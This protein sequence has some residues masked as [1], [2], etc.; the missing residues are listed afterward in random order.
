MARKNT[1][2][3]QLNNLNDFN[4]RFRQ[5]RSIAKNVFGIK[6]IE[7]T[8]I[9]ER[10][11]N[12]KLLYKGALAFYAEP[13]VGLLAL[14][15]NSMGSID[16]FGEPINIQCYGANGQK[17]RILRPGEYVIMYDNT[18]RESILPD[19][20]L[21]AQRMSATAR[22]AD[23]N[24]SQQRTPRI[25]KGPASMEASLKKIYNDIDVNEDVIY[26]YKDFDLDDIQMVLAPAPFVADKL[27]A[28][29]EKVWNE[30]CR[31]VGISDLAI[32]KK[33]RLIKDEVHASQG[34]AVASRFS[35]YTPRVEA[36]D[37][38]NEMFSEYLPAPLEVIYYDHEPETVKEDLQ[39]E[40]EEVFVNEE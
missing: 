15:F 18:E 26:L 24:V 3:S 30:F 21:Y 29:A 39:E 37:K 12:N 5:M 36:V 13:D 31:F 38:I 27:D 20:R 40:N 17:S 32:E 11:I 10:Y 23:I 33:E 14:P 9:T 1:M 25:I 4:V 2:T 6:N 28:H 35:R 16:I 8:G 19:I 22:A 7:K 34:G